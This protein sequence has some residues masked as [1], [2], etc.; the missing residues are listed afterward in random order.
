LKQAHE[1]HIRWAAERAYAGILPW[2]SRISPGL[3]VQFTPLKEK[4]G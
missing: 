3:H 2:A 4:S 1:L